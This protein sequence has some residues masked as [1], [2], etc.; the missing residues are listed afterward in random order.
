MENNKIIARLK[1]AIARQK[2]ENLTQERMIGEM[3]EEIARLEVE[4]MREETTIY[5]NVF[6]NPVTNMFFEKRSGEKVGYSSK[7][8]DGAHTV[9]GGCDQE[10]SPHVALECWRIKSIEDLQKVGEFALIADDYRA[11]RVKGR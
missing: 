10:I 4:A 7:Y 6:Y 3:K 8:Y 11:W 9:I 5:P 2:E 1:R